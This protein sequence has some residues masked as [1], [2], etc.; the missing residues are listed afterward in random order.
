MVILL[1]VSYIIY[2]T[3]IKFE[4]CKICLKV[5]NIVGTQTACYGS[6]MDFMLIGF[7]LAIHFW[8]L[9]KYEGSCI[10]RVSGK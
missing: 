1:L 8:L 9:F 5:L 2:T 10:W 6:P 3:Y 4:K 7:H